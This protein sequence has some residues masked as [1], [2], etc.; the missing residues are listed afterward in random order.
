[1]D[2]NL[3]GWKAGSNGIVVLKMAQVA[4]VII[5]RL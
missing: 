2:P 5:A 3:A 1:M 4:E